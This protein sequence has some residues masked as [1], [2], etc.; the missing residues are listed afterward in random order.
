MSRERLVDMFHACRRLM[1]PDGCT[2]VAL[3]GL[4]AEQTY[5]EHSTALIPAARHAGLGWLQ[6][7]IAVTAPIVGQRITWRATPTNPATLR[8]ATHV[9]VHIDLLVLMPRTGRHG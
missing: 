2:I 7:I 8:A 1:S 3:A 5:I 6:R 4:P 9:K